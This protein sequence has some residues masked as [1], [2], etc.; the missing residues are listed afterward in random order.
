MAAPRQNRNAQKWNRKKVLYYL[1][2]IYKITN[3]RQEL[4]WG[5]ILVKVGLYRDIWRYWRQHYGHIR[6]INHLM[7]L[8]EDNCEVSLLKAGLESRIPARIVMRSLHNIY[9]WGRR[10]WIERE[11]VKE[12]EERLLDEAQV[13]VR[14]LYKSVKNMEL[15][16]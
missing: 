4:F 10:S 14:Q 1:H 8:I 9:G 11:E 6:A 3:D 12:R 5:R 13:A 2:K 15:A 16:A 7:G